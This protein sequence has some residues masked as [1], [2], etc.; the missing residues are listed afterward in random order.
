M[1]ALALIL[2]VSLVVL[3]SC[4]GEEGPVGP[5]GPAGV[6]GSGIGYSN[7]PVAGHGSGI[8]FEEAASVT[9]EITEEQSNV[10]IIATDN[11]WG[12]G[13]ACISVIRLVIDDVVEDN[14]LV[15]VDIPNAVSGNNGGSLTTSTMIVLSQGS[16]TVKLERGGCSSDMN[17]HLNVIVLGN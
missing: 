15:M 6:S 8:T 11:V 5:E 2:L 7:D 17:P 1:R 16:H 12:T 4:E 3:P 9:F 10:F 13:V 14:T